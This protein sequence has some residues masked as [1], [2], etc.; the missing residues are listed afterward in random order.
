MKLLLDEN[1]PGRLKLD[2]KDHYVST[3]DDENWRS[4][5]NGEL[6]RLMIAAGFDVLI[7]LDRKLQH[8]QNFKKYPIPVIILRAKNHEIK[9]LHEFAPK[10]NKLLKRRLKPGPHELSL[11]H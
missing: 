10:L 1:L 6:L 3:V 11:T 5:K 4:I 7:T 9:T 2:L 8:Q